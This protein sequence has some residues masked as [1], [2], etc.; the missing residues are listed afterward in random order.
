MIC[1]TTVELTPSH[2]KK[3]ALFCDLPQQNIIEG[4]D[5][6]SIYEVPLSYAE[7][8]FSDLLQQ[9]LFGETRPTD[10]RD[11]EKFVI[12][13]TNPSKKVTIGIAGKYVQLDDCYLS[14]IEACKHAAVHNDASVEIVWIDTE[15]LEKNNRSDELT[16]IIHQKKVDGLLVPGG[17]G[18]R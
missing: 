17:F 11:W 6:Q 14:V 10:M 1:R 4:R 3:L 13:L 16:T 9:Q 7:Q 15:Q 18:N 2:K 12:K 5:V 8:N